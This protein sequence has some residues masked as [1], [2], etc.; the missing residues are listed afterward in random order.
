[1]VDIENKNN[2]LQ[3][4][5]KRA[6]GRWSLVET[7]K[8]IEVW[9]PMYS[10]RRSGTKDAW[11]PQHIRGRARSS[12]NLVTEDWR[13]VACYVNMYR[14]AAGLDSL[15][16]HDQCKKRVEHLRRR[17]VKERRGWPFFDALHA[18]WGD[19]PA[20]NRAVQAAGGPPAGAPADESGAGAGIANRDE[21]AASPERGTAAAEEECRRGPARWRRLDSF[22]GAVEEDASSAGEGS[23]AAAAAT[24]GIRG[25]VPKRARTLKKEAVRQAIARRGAADGGRGDEAGRASGN[26]NGNGSRVEEVLGGA[27]HGPTDVEAAA[28]LLGGGS[29][30]GGSADAFVVESLGNALTTLAN[31]YEKVTMKRLEHRG[32]AAAPAVA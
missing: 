10:H 26:G 13:A 7:T 3:P 1:M 30:S 16:T 21:A 11:V 8:L 6:F 27:L 5:L 19:E 28:R 15:R 24:N 12:R 23:G 2:P 20:V 25:S 31:V 32:R 9:G 18:V 17:Y 29:P 22:R 4:K 14:A